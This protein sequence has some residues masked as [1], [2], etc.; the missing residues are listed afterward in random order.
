MLTWWMSGYNEDSTYA[1]IVLKGSIK[2]RA[3]SWR[4]NLTFKDRLQAID[5]ADCVYAE[6][7]VSCTHQVEWIQNLR[8][9]K[10]HPMCTI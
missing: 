9:H 2:N 1:Y 7:S 10:V 6:F 3:L 4:Q 8:L 5:G